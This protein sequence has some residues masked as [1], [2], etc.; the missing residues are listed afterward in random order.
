MVPSLPARTP[1]ALGLAGGVALLLGAL[2]LPRGTGVAPA[3]I[4]AEPSATTADAPERVGA[5]PGAARSAAHEGR[6]VRYVD[7]HDHYAH[8]TTVVDPAKYTYFRR[9]GASPEIALT[10]D[11]GWVP[12][13]RG[14]AV[15]DAL[16]ELG[17]RSTFFVAGPFV[18]KSTPARANTPPNDA[19]LRM[20]R[21]I[22]D[23]G[24]EVANHTHTHPH[25]NAQTAWARELGELSRGW[26]AAVRAIYGDAPPPNAALKPYWRA[27]YGEYDERALAAAAAAG[28]PFH[29]GWNV[30]ALDALGI[31]DCRGVPATATGAAC[32]SAERQ[33]RHVLAFAR[34]NP[35]LDVTVVL[36]HLGGPYGW[37]SDPK[38]LRALVTALRAEGRVF[39]RLS[40]VIAVTP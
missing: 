14:L 3:R 30:E 2:A 1:R 28:Y 23:D 40:E 6:P 9:R 10:F 17:V 7:T 39:A 16:R 12:E 37:G 31:P 25:G 38:G 22:L 20:I 24:H 27:P 8:A 5:G 34:R 4:V 35:Q 36:A 11:C 26:S 19:T 15:L 13:A 32:L 21:R 18:F 29:F 33:T